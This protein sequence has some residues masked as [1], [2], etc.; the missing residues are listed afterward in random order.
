MKIRLTMYTIGPTLF[1]DPERPGWRWEILD[2]GGEVL[3]MGEGY[4]DNGKARAAAEEC[5]ALFERNGKAP[6]EGR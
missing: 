1:G 6:R 4:H 5:R 2:E 3:A